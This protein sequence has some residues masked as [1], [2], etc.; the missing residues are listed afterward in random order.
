M[1]LGKPFLS[2]WIRIRVELEILIPVPIKSGFGS[3]TL[4]NFSNNACWAWSTVTALGAFFKSI[5]HIRRRC[6][7]VKIKETTF[8]CCFRN[9][10]PGA[11]ICLQPAPQEE[12]PTCWYRAPFQLCHRIKYRAFFRQI[13]YNSNT[14]L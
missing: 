11:P 3:A 5:G 8:C 10:L 7:S 2:F 1:K 6:W 12:T 4:T 14:V 13:C 9:I